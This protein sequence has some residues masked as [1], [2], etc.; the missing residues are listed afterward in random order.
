MAPWFPRSHPPCENQSRY[1]GSHAQVICWHVNRR[2]PKRCHQLTCVHPSTCLDPGRKG[3]WEIIG[4]ILERS[5]NYQLPFG[6]KNL[7]LPDVVGKFVM[8]ST[9]AILYSAHNILNLLGI[10]IYQ[11]RCEPEFLTSFLRFVRIDRAH[12]MSSRSLGSV[13]IVDQTRSTSSSLKFL[14]LLSTAI[15]RGLS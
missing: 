2:F 1:R 11:I 8:D 13:R 4:G 9:R 5:S 6:Y 3:C 7:P 10:F 12:L 15:K 14:G